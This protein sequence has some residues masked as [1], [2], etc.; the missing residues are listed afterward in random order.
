MDTVRI[1]IIG[2]GGVAAAAHIPA[3]LQNDHVK[4]TAVCDV[5]LKRAK[6]AR[7]KYFKKAA[8]YED[9]ME[10]LADENVDAVD[11][12]TP[13]FLHA[14]IAVE[15]FRAGKHVLCE[16]PDAISVEEAEKMYAASIEAD[17]LLMVVRNHRF[18]LNA[19]YLKTFVEKER[20]GE[21][22]V[23]RAVWKRRRGI[24]G[25]G[26]WFTTKELSGGGPL[27]DLGVH[28]IDLA[29]WLM[30]CPE[31]EAV[32]GNTYSMFADNDAVDSPN[33]KFGDRVSD[34]TCDVEDLAIG[35][36]RF[37]NGSVLQFETSWASNIYRE[38][39][40]VELYGSKAGAFWDGARDEIYYES[41]GAKQKT[42]VVNQNE[43]ASDHARNIANFVDV[44][45]GKADP[46]YTPQ[47]GI[48]MIKILSAI[49]TSAENG[50]K[51]IHF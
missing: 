34:G 48:E 7:R 44:L 35:T 13:N 49:Y 23:A 20:M 14:E 51:E 33:A 41:P 30:G 32:T 2:I 16:K 19:Q 18:N 3:L 1:G 10:L 45:R 38:E 28:V 36:I 22:Y 24:P 26:G 4:V 46:V 42:H 8:V 27:I 50:G 6:T 17:R 43:I 47:Q 9:Y 15:A 25:K 37:R 11:I 29:W 21:I 40:Y 12:L 31:V 5:D 39:R